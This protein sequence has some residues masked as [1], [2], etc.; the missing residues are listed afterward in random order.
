MIG[1][2][3][4]LVGWHRWLY[5]FAYHDIDIVERECSRWRDL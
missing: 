5:G 3:L 1:K 4:C 2:L